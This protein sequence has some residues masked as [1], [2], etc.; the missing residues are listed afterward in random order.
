MLWQWKALLERSLDEHE[1]ALASFA[2]AARLDPA[3]VSI[4]H[5]H[6]RTAMEAGLDA[7]P[8]YER[9]LSLA[10]RNGQI[11]IGLAA[12]RAATGEGD[13]AVSDLQATLESRAGVAVRP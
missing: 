4:A 8:L 13:R 10:P 6:A 5:G 1:Q 7:G 3:D 11:L 9:A 2:E 12:A